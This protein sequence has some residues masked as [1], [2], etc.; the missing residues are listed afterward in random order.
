MTARIAING[1]GRIGRSVLRALYECGYREHLEPAALNEPA[2][3]AAIGYLTR[4]DTVHGRFPD[5]VEEGD[6]CLRIG[7]DELRLSAE[8]DPA[9]LPW[10]DLDIDIVLE[11]SGRFVV[12][13]ELRRHLDAGARRVLLSQ[14]G[15]REIPAVVRGVNDESRPADAQIVS[16]ASCTT[17]AVTP[18]I[19]VLDRALGAEGG[20]ITTLHSAMNDQPVLDA[21]H[22]CSDLRLMRAAGSSMI[23]AKTQLAQGIG[24]ILPHLDGCFS[25]CAMRVPVLNV[26]AM[27]LLL[28]V[29]RSTDVEAVNELLAAASQGALAGILGYSEEPLASCDFNH[30]RRSGIVDADQTRVSCGHLVNTLIWFDNEWGFANRMLDL[31]CILAGEGASDGQS[32]R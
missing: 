28:Q 16:C 5:A 8:T 6:G 4:H 1:Y 11:C 19:A 30:D 29:R 24:R 20:T 2:P 32:G 7:E 26:S 31:A 25:A 12:P 17:N 23:P 14:P 9:H 18:V 3:A 10:R 13:R 22:G 21:Y 27:N 15:S